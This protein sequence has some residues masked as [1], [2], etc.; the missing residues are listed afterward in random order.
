MSLGLGTESVSK[1]PTP[2]DEALVA[3]FAVK[4]LP[5]IEYVLKPDS[6]IRKV[7]GPYTITKDVYFEVI[8]CL[9]EAMRD[10]HF[11]RSQSG[12]SS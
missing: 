6:G 4:V 8:N 11:L 9:K 10:E 2:I 3:T 7:N 1:Q 5:R 12:K